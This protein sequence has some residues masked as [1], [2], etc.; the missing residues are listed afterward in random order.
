MDPVFA[1]ASLRRGWTAGTLSAA[2]SPR[3]ANDNAGRTM[4]SFEHI[5]VESKDQVYQRCN[6]AAERAAQVAH[7][8]R[9]GARGD[10]RL[11]YW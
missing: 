4:R 6:E 9:G 2:A 10:L 11:E 5:I 1:A 7:R 8:H 3:P